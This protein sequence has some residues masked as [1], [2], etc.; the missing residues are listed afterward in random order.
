VP[1]EQSVRVGVVGVGA[2]GQHH[3]RVCSDLPNARL[4]GV[5][6]VDRQRAETIATRHGCEAFV[7]LPSLLAACDAVAVAVPTVDHHRVARAALDAGKDVL[8]E[9]P[10]TT[11]LEEADDLIAEASRRGRVLQVGHIERFNPAVDVLR[12]TASS[13]RF[14]EVHRLGSFSARSLDI[15]VVLDLMVHDLDIVLALDGSDP[16]QVDAVGIPV[17]TPKIDIANARLKFAS[18][19]IANVTASRVSA[20]KVRKFRV[21]APRTYVSA[22]FARREA[23]VYRL[24]LR[25]DGRPA[26]SSA[27]TAAPEVEP[28]RRQAEAFV[29]AVATRGEPVVGGRDGRRAL[30]LAHTILRQMAA[31]GTSW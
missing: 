29:H 18:G 11:T 12:A 4:V 19:L 8:I 28:L 14:I 27:R 20:E 16:I 9:K 6:D 24:V 3:A 7:S 10:M 17:L 2:L 1:G 15:D 26:L 31:D 21:F 25:E 23:Q 22:D 30:A 13:P 5:H